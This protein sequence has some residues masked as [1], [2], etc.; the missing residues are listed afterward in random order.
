MFRLGCSSQPAPTPTEGRTA[1]G[2]SATAQPTYTAN[3]SHAA[4]PHHQ[5]PAGVCTDSFNCLLIVCTFTVLKHL[6]VTNTALPL[7]S[8]PFQGIESAS[9]TFAAAA[10]KKQVPNI[11]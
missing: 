1:P 6:K 2:S 11:K 5:K 3:S 4:A 9:S 8:T 7:S 10:Q